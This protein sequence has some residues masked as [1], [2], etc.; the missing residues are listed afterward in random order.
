VRALAA[1][2]LR[3]LSVSVL[4]RFFLNL[5]IHVFKAEEILV[6]ASGLLAVLLVLVELDWG[7]KLLLGQEGVDLLDELKSGVLLVQDES[8]D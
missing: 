6:V 8:I 1:T 2:K 7:Q 3:L 4:D 5:S